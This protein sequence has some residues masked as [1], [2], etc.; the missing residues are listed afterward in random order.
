MADES[1]GHSFNG[2]IRRNLKRARDFISPPPTGWRSVPNDGNEYRGYQRIEW[3]GPGPRPKARSPTA[4]EEE[5]AAVIQRQALEL[6]QQKQ[7]QINYMI[8]ELNSVSGMALDNQNMLLRYV[9]A[10][11]IKTHGVGKKTINLLINSAIV[12]RLAGEVKTSACALGS[13]A[14]ACVKTAAGV[15]SR[16]ASSAASSAKRRFLKAI[17]PSEIPVAAVPVQQQFFPPYVSPEALRAFAGQAQAAPGYASAASQ[18]Q[19]EYMDR[20]LQLQ[21]SPY[22]P[23][24]APPPPPPP[25]PPAPA[26][27]AEEDI[28]TICMAGPGINDS[29]IDRGLLGYVE[30][31]G[32]GAQGHPNKFHQ[33]CLQECLQLDARCPMCRAHDPVW[34]MQRPQRQGGGSRKYRSKF[35]SKSKSKTRRLRKSR[36]K[37]RKPRKS[38][39]SRKPR[40]SSRRK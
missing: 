8:A 36:N 15:L 28:C 26:L 3:D 25:A 30:I 12:R 23:A 38:C 6:E 10:S 35:R 17:R 34:G 24:S 37:S 40:S 2:S 9:V 13:R 5:E 16:G 27:D 32:N 21:L 11:V 31:H 14:A 19:Q 7:N 20:L 22:V 33:S 1:S 18:Q 39:K 29:G 4:E